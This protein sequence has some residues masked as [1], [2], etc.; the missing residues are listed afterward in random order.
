MTQISDQTFITEKYEG[1]NT[2]KHMKAK[3]QKTRLGKNSFKKLGIST[4]QVSLAV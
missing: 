3:L 1:R 4:D 2:V